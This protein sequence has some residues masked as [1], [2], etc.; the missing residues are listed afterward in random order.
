MSAL[1]KTVS[2]FPKVRPK[3]TDH[4]DVTM[5][6]VEHDTP[7]PPSAR[8]SLPSKYGP[9]FDK[10]KPG[11]CIVC[12]FSE[13]EHVKSA[14]HKYIKRHELDCVAKS[15]GRCADGHARVWLVKRPEVK[16]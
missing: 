7:L 16:K 11:S 14:L 4:I 8:S 3:N 15:V 12:E 1:S 6:K 5:L 13:R 2:H 9:L 10:L